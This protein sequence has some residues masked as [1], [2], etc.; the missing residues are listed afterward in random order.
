[1]YIGMYAYVKNRSSV[2][3]RSVLENEKQRHIYISM[4]CKW[5]MKASANCSGIGRIVYIHMYILT[6]H[7]YKCIHIYACMLFTCTSELLNQKRI[8]ISLLYTTSS[9]F[10]NFCVYIHTSMCI[11]TFCSC[12]CAYAEIRTWGPFCVHLSGSLVNPIARLTSRRT[13]TF[14]TRHTNFSKQ[15]HTYINTY[16][17]AYERLFDVKTQLL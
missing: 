14:S 6:I 2:K 4:V 7:I 17:F 12:S 16:V 3:K 11:C 1:M 8:F 5:R 9:H 10:E 15:M 13:R